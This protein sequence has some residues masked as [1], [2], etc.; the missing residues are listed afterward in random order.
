MGGIL[1][2]LGV[3][4]VG[5]TGGGRGGGGELAVEVWEWSKGSRCLVQL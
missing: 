2:P 4:H 5:N 3:V 1:S